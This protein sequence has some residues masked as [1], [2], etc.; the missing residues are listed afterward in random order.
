MNGVFRNDIIKSIRT[1]NTPKCTH[2]RLPCTKICPDK[3]FTHLR[4]HTH[5]QNRQKQKT[6]TEDEQSKITIKVHSD[7]TQI[8]RYESKRIFIIKFNVFR[9]FVCVCVCVKL[10][11]RVAKSFKKLKRNKDKS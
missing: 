10:R 5:S 8:N 3:H 2:A 7:W 11:L 6:S 9:L 4:V 1:T